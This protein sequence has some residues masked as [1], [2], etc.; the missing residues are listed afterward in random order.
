MDS[1]NI[2]AYKKFSDTDSKHPTEFLEYVT[3]VLSE[4][5]FI[6]SFKH[7]THYVKLCLDF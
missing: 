6:V 3:F 7:I 5:T 2:K 1:T 4:I